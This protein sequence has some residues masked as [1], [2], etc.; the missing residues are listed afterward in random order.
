[1]KEVVKQIYFIIKKGLHKCK[2]FFIDKIIT[3]VSEFIT[4]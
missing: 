4:S 1:M 3:E 2:P